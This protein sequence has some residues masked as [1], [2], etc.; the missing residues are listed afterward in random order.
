[1]AKK[2]TKAKKSSQSK[3]SKSETEIIVTPKIATEPEDNKLTVQFTDE[4]DVVLDE[5]KVDEEELQPLL[6]CLK[7]DLGGT[8]GDPLKSRVSGVFTFN[9]IPRKEK[10]ALA[11]KTGKGRFLTYGITEDA[12]KHRWVARQALGTDTPLSPEDLKLFLVTMKN[13]DIKKKIA[14][15]IGSARAY[16]HCAAA[17][18]HLNPGD[19]SSPKVLRVIQYDRMQLQYDSKN[20]F[21]GLLTPILHGTMAEYTLIPPEQLVL[22]INEEHPSGFLDIGLSVLESVY[23]YIK[24]ATLIM[25]TWSRLYLQRGLGLI[26]IKVMNG[27]QKDLDA[28]KAEFKDPTQYSTMVYNDRLEVEAMPGI[29]AGYSI[30]ETNE[31]FMK[32]VSS[33]SG[34]SFTKLDG[35]NTYVSGV[36]ADQDNYASNHQLLHERWHDEIIK[37]IE[38]CEPRLKDKIALDFIIEIKLDKTQEIQVQST[39]LTMAL[40]CPELFTVNKVLRELD[41]DIQE[42][43]DDITLAEYLFNKR[44][45]I[46]GEEMVMAIGGMENGTQGD[47]FNERV[48]KNDEKVKGNTNL[49]LKN[50]RKELK[51]KKQKLA[52]SVIQQSKSTPYVDSVSY[53]EVR[54][55]LDVFFGNALSKSTLQEIYDDIEDA[56][57]SENK[58]IEAYISTIKIENLTDLS[59][60]DI[61]KKLIVFDSFKELDDDEKLGITFEIYKRSRKTNGKL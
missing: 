26:K 38:M 17:L 44:I 20:N 37:V 53:N 50:S 12:F 55:L 1:M 30:K 4:K 7:D 60:S 41:V 48:G 15:L 36:L 27:K 24:G 34:I 42:G 14:N 39:F 29:N 56:E 13:F 35:G 51:N 59:I 61:A 40:T 19:T 8:I 43:G 46:Y 23:Y 5:I 11:H 57:I 16:G 25:D 2:S 33:G 49:D 52:K 31:M 47:L 54:K 18:T 58:R 21:E 6:L 9:E 10:Q 22:F 28:V 45:E 32:E 3:V